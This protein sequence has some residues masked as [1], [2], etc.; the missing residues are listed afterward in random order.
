MGAKRNLYRIVVEKP[1]RKR[2]LGR[3]RC[4]HVDNIKMEF[5]DITW[6]GMDW[7]DVAP[8]RDQ[9]RALVN[10]VINLRVP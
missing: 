3:P 2:P 8:D 10:T 7:I 6:C 5:R 9:W 1:E 4:R